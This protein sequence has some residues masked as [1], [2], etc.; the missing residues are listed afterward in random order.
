MYDSLI[1]VQSYDKLYHAM[2]RI[3]EI[4]M[5]MSKYSS[6]PENIEKIIKFSTSQKPFSSEAPDGV[7]L[8]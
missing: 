7:A 3:F 6:S 2:S 5:E 1:S 8:K 4:I